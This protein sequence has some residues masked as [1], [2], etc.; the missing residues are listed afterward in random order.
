MSMYNSI[1]AYLQNTDPRH[2]DMIDVLAYGIAVREAKL[3]EAYFLIHIKLKPKWMPD[4]LYKFI[5][6]RVVHLTMFKFK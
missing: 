6:R 3:K 2:S 5:L 4:F 1:E